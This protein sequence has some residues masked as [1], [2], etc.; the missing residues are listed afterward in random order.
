MGCPK[1][2]S[3]RYGLTNAVNKRSRNASGLTQRNLISSLSNW[4]WSVGGLRSH[5]DSGP[6]LPA[7][8]DLHH[9]LCNGGPSILLANGGGECGEDRESPTW[10][11]HVLSTLIP[12][13]RTSDTDSCHTNMNW[14]IQSLAGLLTLRY[15]L[16]SGSEKVGKHLEGSWPSL[17]YQSNF[18]LSLLSSHYGGHVRDWDR[19]PHPHCF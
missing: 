18:H 11:R 3:S 19:A 8:L 12:P 4:S 16:W 15:T 5:G 7:N 10:R 1:C 17:L 6:Q 9:P 2:K 14:E 13:A